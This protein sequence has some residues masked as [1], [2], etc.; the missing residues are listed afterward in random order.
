M[1]ITDDRDEDKIDET[2]AHFFNAMYRYCHKGEGGQTIPKP[3]TG[4]VRTSRRNRGNLCRISSALVNNSPQ[5]SQC[6][7]VTSMPIF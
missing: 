3:E 7:N 4:T 6:R 1:S 5:Y 2:F